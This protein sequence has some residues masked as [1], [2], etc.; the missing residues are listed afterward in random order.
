MRR[1]VDLRVT[2]QDDGGQCS[3]RRRVQSRVRRCQRGR[4]HGVE[5]TWRGLAWGEETEARWLLRGQQQPGMRIGPRPA[6]SVAA[7]RGLRSAGLRLRRGRVW[8]QGPGRA[9]GEGCASGAA[10]AHGGPRCAARRGVGGVGWPAG[11]LYGAAR[12]VLV[13]GGPAWG[14]LPDAV[15]ARVRGQRLGLTER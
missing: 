8:G 12:C 14:W 3:G 5:T 6:L 13:P 4:R 15:P 11:P 7:G 2:F 1:Y 9:R 10:A